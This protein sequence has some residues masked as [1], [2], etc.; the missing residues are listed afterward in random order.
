MIGQKT[1]RGSRKPYV[2]DSCYGKYKKRLFVIQPSM[3]EKDICRQ[4]FCQRV[5]MISKVI[6][7]TR[8]RIYRRYFYPANDRHSTR[9]DS[10]KRK[11]PVLRV[12]VQTD[13]FTHQKVAS[14]KVL[15]IYAP[16]NSSI[17]PP[18]H[19]FINPSIY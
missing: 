15:Y 12:T 18:I 9:T 1:L 8:K 13:H 11:F 2:G 3:D 10:T 17:H 6:G 16:I 5:P 4:S 19:P 7:Q 14:D